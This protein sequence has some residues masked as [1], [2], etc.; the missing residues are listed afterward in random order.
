MEVMIQKSESADTLTQAKHVYLQEDELFV[1][2][3]S[4]RFEWDIT[5]VRNADLV[6]VAD[7][8][9]SETEDI[10][11][12]DIY[13][14][15]KEVATFFCDEAMQVSNRVSLDLKSGTSVE[16]SGWIASCRNL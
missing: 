4:K 6:S 10:T 2:D 8:H 7:Y 13:A 9:G 12:E 16:I 11:G 5:S 15:N 1:D 14:V 3:Q